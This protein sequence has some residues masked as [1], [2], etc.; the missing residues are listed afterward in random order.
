MPLRLSPLVH[1]LGPAPSAAGPARRFLASLLPGLLTSLLVGASLVTAPAAHAAGCVGAAAAPAVRPAQAAPVDAREA[2]RQ[3]VQLAL[4][5]NP[6]LAA[7][8]LIAEAALDDLRETQA[9]RQPQA[10]LSTGGGPLASWAGRD[11][12]TSAAQLRAGVSVSQLLY[13][14]GRTERLIDVRRLQG[15]A[16]RQSHLGQQEQ[17][18]LATVSAAFELSRLREQAQVYAEYR[19]SATCLVQALEQVVAADR[20]RLSELVQARKSLA[21]VE[22]TQAQTEAQ[23]RQSQLRLA[24][25]V[26]DLRPGPG[27]LDQALRELPSLAQVL[28]ETERSAELRQLEAQ[29]QAADALADSV[30]AATRP[31]L[32][33]SAGLNQ[34]TNAGG[35]LPTRHGGSLSV[36]LNLTIPLYSPGNQDAVAAA[37]KR[38]QAA[39]LQR[40]DAL[41]QRR[42]RIADLHDQAGAAFDRMRQTETILR[43]SERLRGFTLEQWQQLG[44]R[45]LF[46]VMAAESD[47][48]GL[49]IAQVNARHDGQQ[50]NATLQSLGGGLLS[51][52]R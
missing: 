27:T 43:D 50:I 41:E 22:L 3:L 52:L 44:R 21:Q 10:S 47:H 5:R 19:D 34:S 35:T 4:Q 2:L 28:A 33:W 48:F 51:L 16:L 25:F 13:D 36:G 26:G 17:L 20:G 30:V 46:D 11:T 24:R 31:Q 1:R 42:A 23:L 38:A 18:A 37:R 14:G 49:R 7:A 32:S 39:L 6:G 45:S 12:D 40:D 9:S 8:R 29:A 15:E